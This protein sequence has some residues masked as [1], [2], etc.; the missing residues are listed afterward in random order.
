MTLAQF[1]D[2]GASVG[3]YFDVATDK[4][5]FGSNSFTC[6][7]LFTFSGDTSSCAWINASYVQVIFGTGGKLDLGSSVS[8][9]PDKLRAQCIAGSACSKNIAASTLTIYVKAPNNPLVP[10]VIVNLP[11]QSGSCNNLSVDASSS[12]G[13]G[14][15]S[16]YKILWTV[17]SSKVGSTSATT[18]QSFLRRKGSSSDTVNKIISI[19]SSYLAS[20][21]YTMTLSLTNFLL[22]TSSASATV[23]V[24]GNKN[25]P[26]LKIT[27]G[28]T[29]SFYAY[30][31]ASMSVVA[32]VSFCA[33][34]TK[35]NYTSAV[36]LNDVRLS[37]VKTSSIDPR[38]FKLAPYTLAAGYTYKV[39]FNATSAQTIDFPPA[40]ATAF[41]SL[42]ITRGLVVA[43]IKGG[44]SRQ[45][46]LDKALLLDASGSS[47]QD[48]LVASLSYLWSCSIVSV[49]GFG[50]DCSTVFGTGIV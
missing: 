13:N 19:P 48:V 20:E 23:T 22:A 38:T 16:W 29:A 42:T 34:T 11:L 2:T 47:D 43:A 49:N 25:L 32:T 31:T 15:R 26:T 28:N 7:L 45:V 12:S 33:T 17:T 8:L 4:A 24:V 3:I 37:G 30:Q 5:G 14:G 6:S 39:L 27:G 18:I 10:T 50:A 40:T 36:F 21:T 9:L 35:I 41:G 46:S 44:S 1:S